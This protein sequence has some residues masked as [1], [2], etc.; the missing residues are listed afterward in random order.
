MAQARA[1]G[2][3][4]GMQAMEAIK[5]SVAQANAAKIDEAQQRVM[6]FK[7]KALQYFSTKEA[8]VRV[9]WG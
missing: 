8:E 5:S 6:Q 7:D 2:E 4:D 9:G 3:A 1:D